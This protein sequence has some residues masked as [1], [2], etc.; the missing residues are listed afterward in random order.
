MPGVMIARHRRVEAKASRTF[1]RH[2][3][4]FLYVQFLA[5]DPESL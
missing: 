3:A 5:A 1:R 2:E 4:E